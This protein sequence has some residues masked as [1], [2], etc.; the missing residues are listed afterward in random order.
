MSILFSEE[1][2]EILQMKP[3]KLIIHHILCPLHEDIIRK[4]GITNKSELS[5]L[6]V[7]CIDSADSMKGNQHQERFI[8][9]N[10]L[11]QIA[12]SSA[13]VPKLHQLPDLTNHI[14]HMEN[15]IIANF[16][17]HV[18]K[19][20]EHV[21]AMFEKL[22]QSVYQKIENKRRQLI[23]TLDAQLKAFQDVFGFYKQKVLSYKA[24]HKESVT[25][26]A[27]Y[28]E[29]SE[30]T[31]APDLQK[32][33]TMHYENMKTNEIF[34]QVTAD[35]AEKLVVDAIEAMDSELLKF[36]T[37]KP[38]ITIGGNNEG[39][40]EIIK[41]W[42]DQVDAIIN[43]L[44]F[45]I[46]NRVT[47]IG[48]QI[49]S[50]VKFDS[51]ILKNDLENKKMIENWVLETIKANRVRFKLLYRGS[52]DGFGAK[53]FHE[54]CDN[55]G[56]TIVVVENTAGNKFG[57]YAAVSWTS[58]N[59]QKID[60]PE[61]FSSFLFSVDTK[62]KLLYQPDS[63]QYVL[64]HSSKYGP[65]FGYGPA[66]S[67]ADNCNVNNSN[68]CDPKYNSYQNL[69]EGG[70]ISGTQNFIVKEIEVYSVVRI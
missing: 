47:P 3:A 38:M 22:R 25:F 39:F 13:K 43:E 42:S 62:E 61:S 55:K 21:N 45:D 30:L 24:D 15:E 12:Q 9:E 64:Y 57:G 10:F 6:C 66:L 46:T 28:K 8:L 37:I 35:E 41:K 26:D 52:R 59:G 23:V 2:F 54:K 40:E 60:S 44:R 36:Q 53:D 67:I 56:P 63:N 48:F 32:F 31:N 17:S 34:T 68:Y 27:L 1:N 65:D 5:I 4:V 50:S 19:Q 16:S 70:F 18:E 33:L 14:L 49:Q 51:V 58:T 29:V 69:K 11:N 20:K 7:S